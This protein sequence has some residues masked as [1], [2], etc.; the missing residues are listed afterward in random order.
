[1]DLMMSV[2]DS[3]TV[4]DFGKVIATGTPQ[5]VQDNPAVTAAYLGIS[6][7]EGPADE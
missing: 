5:Q 3:I 6:G 7:D 2:C 1:M 4:L